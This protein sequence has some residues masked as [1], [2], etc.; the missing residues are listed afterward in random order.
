MINWKERIIMM[1]MVKNALDQADKEQLWEYHY[2][3][4]AAQIKEILSVQKKLNVKFS[5]EY[6]EFLQCANGWK[7]IY[8]LVDLFGT[9]DFD[10]ESMEY[11]RKLLKM[12]MVNDKSLDRLGGS[13]VPIAVSRTDKDLFV[14]ILAEGK[15]YGQVIWLAGGEV[16]RF[17]SFCDFFDAMIEYSKEELKDMTADAM[18]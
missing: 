8:Q 12:E 14:M 4:V 15:E 16:E 11:A 2:P 5:E 9:R 3:E 10:S 13:L 17:D 18:N 7:A 6:T 1:L